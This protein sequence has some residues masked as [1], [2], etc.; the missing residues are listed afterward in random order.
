MLWNPPASPEPGRIQD[1]SDGSNKTL[2]E[3]DNF[4]DLEIL[5]TDKDAEGPANQKPATTQHCPCL[6]RSKLGQSRCE[7]GQDQS[8]VRYVWLKIER[9]LLR[10]IPAHTLTASHYHWASQFYQHSQQHAG[11]S[12]TSL[13]PRSPNHQSEL[14]QP[15]TSPLAVMLMTLVDSNIHSCTQPAWVEQN[16]HAD[17][18]SA[19]LDIMDPGKTKEPQC[20]RAFDQN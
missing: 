5:S 9:I 20:E 16:K 6:S 1:E 17:Q 13:M 19:E 7:F 4:N 18:P 3:S 10:G 12:E 2:T 8:K 11:P 15:S 14:D